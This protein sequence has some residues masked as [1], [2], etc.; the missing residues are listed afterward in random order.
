GLYRRS[1]YT[2]WKRTAP[3]PVMVTFDA[4]TREVCTPKREST[5]TPLQALVLM[6]G[7]QYVEAARALGE[8]LMTEPPAEANDD[9]RLDIAFRLCTSRLPGDDEREILR[10]LLAEQR[11]HFTRHPTEAAK[12][13]KVGQKPANSALD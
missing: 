10:R 5:A 3:P 9:A 11:A 4:S 6:N 1:L 8:R 13:L 12:L 7:P 2:F